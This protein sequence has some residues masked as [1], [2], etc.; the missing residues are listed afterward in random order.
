MLRALL[1]STLA[2]GLGACV[3]PPRPLPYI[4]KP[5]V[6]PAP[7][8]CHDALGHARGNRPWVFGGNC[9]CTPTQAN[10]DAHAA[11]GTMQPDIS[12]AQFVEAY[13]AKGILTELDTGHRACGN[14]CTEGP[15]VTLGGRCMA[16][17]VFGTPMYERATYGPHE[18][19][20][21]RLAAR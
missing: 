21:E 3:A 17:P 12:Y 18:P 6:A 16:T 20:A 10:Y 15:H 19:A 13:R 9:C 14:L 2:L 7:L 4:P 1:L 8:I 5:A 11:A